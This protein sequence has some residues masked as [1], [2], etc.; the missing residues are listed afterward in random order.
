MKKSSL[1]NLGVMA[2]VLCLVTTCLL[3]GTLAKFVSKTSV[4]A[5]ATVAKWSF[6]VKDDKNA[7]L[8][9]FDLS[10]TSEEYTDATVNGAVIAPGTKGSFKIN[11]DKGDSQVGVSYKI[12]IAAASGTTLPADLTFKVDNAAYNLGEDITG[13]I[14]ANAA[15]A[16]KEVIV[17]WE[18]DYGAADTA[19]SNDNSYQGTNWNINVEVTGEQIQPG[20]QSTP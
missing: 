11:L 19:D 1:R 4:T 5:T 10:T 16:T 3:G 14:D 18:W 15:N 6:D 20:T 17:D 2:V 8:A 9:N 12:N 13:T 7:T